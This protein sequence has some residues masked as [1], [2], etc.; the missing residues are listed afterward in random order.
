[1]GFLRAIFI[2]LRD[3]GGWLSECYF[4]CAADFIYA[5]MRTHPC[6]HVTMLANAGF[7]ICADSLYWI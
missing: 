3:K 1:M 6:L 4:R 7:P 2:A 5:R